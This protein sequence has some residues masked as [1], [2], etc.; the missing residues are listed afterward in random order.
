MPI[1]RRRRRAAGQTLAEV[2]IVLPLL[3]LLIF[4]LLELGWAMY[5]SN[6]MRG[7]VREA[8]NIISRNGTIED[9]EVGVIAAAAA[10]G[11][12][13]I[14]TESDTSKLIFSVVTRASSGDN[15]G[16]PIIIQRHS[17]GTLDEQSVLG[18]PPSSAFG[19][20]PDYNARNPSDDGRLVATLP[21]NYTLEEGQS[22]FVT[23]IYTRRERI[24]DIGEL[25]D[26]LYA[27]AFF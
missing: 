15:D 11:P 4:G 19:G 3:F 25:P 23:E 14:G 5:Q 22:L 20:A 27:S 12:V 7:Y 2:A 8:S 6:V 9:A 17:I 16:L 24:V 13:E 21:D 26:V 18:D 1:D 10:G